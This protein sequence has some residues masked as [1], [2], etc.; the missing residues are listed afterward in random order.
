M[1]LLGT[2]LRNTRAGEE[3]LAWHRP[4]LA[5]PDRFALWSPDFTPEGELP[6]AHLGNRAGGRNISPALAWDGIPTAAAQLL[7]VVEDA[8]SPTKAPFV[9]AL[10]LLDPRLPALPTAGLHPDVQA[11]GVRLLRSERGRGYLGPA[12]LRGHGPHRYA[13]QLFALAKEIPADG[14]GGARPAAVLAAVRGP[15]LSRGRLDTSYAR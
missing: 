7:L 8:D 5:A 2:L 13:F 10:A 11:R 14:L 1:A 12:P 6:S 4:A 9:H 15:A 3:R